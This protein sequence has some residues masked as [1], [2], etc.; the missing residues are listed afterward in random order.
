MLDS[1]MKQRI[2][3]IKAAYSVIIFLS[4]LQLKS[5]AKNVVSSFILTFILFLI[6]IP[7]DQTL[8]NYVVVL[9]IKL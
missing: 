8:P 4:D 1:R 7:K 2:A 3:A 9:H 6:L 5:W